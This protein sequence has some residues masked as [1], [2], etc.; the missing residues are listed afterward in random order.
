MRVVTADCRDET[1][2]MDDNVDEIFEFLQD[3]EVVEG[4]PELYAL[5]AELWPDLLHKVKPP[6]ELMH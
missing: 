3:A 1:F 6:I 4:P 2:D 5:V